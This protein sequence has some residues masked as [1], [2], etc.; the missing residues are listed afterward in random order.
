M[1][2]GSL[3]YLRPQPLDG[4]GCRLAASRQF[5]HAA[6]AMFRQEIGGLG[7]A[8]QVFHRRPSAV[9]G[10]LLGLDVILDVDEQPGLSAAL[11]RLSGRVDASGNSG[12]Q[13]FFGIVHTQRFQTSKPLLTGS[14]AGNVFAPLDLIALPLQATEQIF[15]VFN[16]GN[17]PVYGGFQL[18][19]IA[20]AVLRGLML[21]V[22]FTLVPAGNDYGQTQGLLR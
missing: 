14:T 3:L 2:G 21:N 4:G 12:G 7:H 17:Q 20:G 22:A 11:L 13:G 6:D 16:G 15:K 5:L 8:F 1:L 19:L 9:S 10:A 18:C